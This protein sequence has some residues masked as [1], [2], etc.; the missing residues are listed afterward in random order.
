[1]A[2]TGVAQ[3]DKMEDVWLPEEESF[4]DVLRRLV[5]LSQSCCS[6]GCW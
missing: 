4:G 2:Q 3:S 6:A 5:E 1:M